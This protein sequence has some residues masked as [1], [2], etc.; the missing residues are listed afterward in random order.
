[1]PPEYFY[2]LLGFSFAAFF[3]VMGTVRW[4]LGQRFKH[5]QGAVTSGDPERLMALEGRIAELEE[6]LDFAERLLA[7]GSDLRQEG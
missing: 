3:G 4:Y 7:R 5:Q 1:M 2:P 6:R